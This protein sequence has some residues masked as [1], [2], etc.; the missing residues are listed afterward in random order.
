MKSRPGRRTS[1]L[2]FV[3]ALTLLA[4]FAG[5]WAAHFASAQADV[6]TLQVREA[7]GAMRMLSLEVHL[8]TLVAN[9]PDFSGMLKTAYG[10]IEM[11]SGFV[12]ATANG[13]GRLVASQMPADRMSCSP[14]RL[15]HPALADQALDTVECAPT[16]LDAAAR[17]NCSAR[18]RAPLW[19]GGEPGI[20]FLF[21][22]GRI[23]GKPCSGS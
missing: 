19:P 7:A 2:E 21:H 15:R 4:A 10:E 9:Q 16:E 14:L 22:S 11:H 17:P 20:T 1:K 3:V 13:I 8:Q 12:A 5:W 6:R 18:Y 23:E